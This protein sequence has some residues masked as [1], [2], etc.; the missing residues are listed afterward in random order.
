MKASATTAP[1]IRSDSL[2]ELRRV[3]EK[4]PALCEYLGDV[5]QVVLFL[6]ACCV[7]SELRWRVD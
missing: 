5:L 1:F 3:V 6:D 7:Q 2:P 4:L